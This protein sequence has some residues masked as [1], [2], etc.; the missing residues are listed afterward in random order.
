LKLITPYSYLKAVSEGL[1]ISAADEATVEQ[2]VRQKQIRVLIYNSQ[3]T[4]NNIQALITLARANNIPVATLT[5]TLTPANASY[6]DWQ[7]AQLQGIQS[8][9]ALATG[10]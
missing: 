7:V 9:L 2:Q 4:P 6:Q 1:D 3:N 10:K 8:A 5:E